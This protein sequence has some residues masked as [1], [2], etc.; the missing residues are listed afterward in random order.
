MKVFI[1]TNVLVSAFSSTRFCSDLIPQI[2]E[3]HELVVST[4]VMEELKR[5]LRTKLVVP[6]EVVL[7]ATQFLNDRATII[8][9]A[10]ILEIPLRDNDDVRILSEAMKAKSDFFITGDKEVLSLGRIGPMQILS[11]RDFLELP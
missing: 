10:P 2:L 7:Q 1:D 3:S 4:T 11:P 6:E 5:V 9:S 8:E